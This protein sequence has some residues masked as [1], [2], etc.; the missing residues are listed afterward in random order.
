[1]RVKR[2][3]NRKDRR[4]KILN[5]AEGYWGGKSRLHRTAKI[6]V[7]KSLQYAYRDR[8]QRKRQFRSL[9]I[10]RINAA[11]RLNGMSYSNFI[12]GLKGAGCDL[13]RKVLADLAVR[14]PQAFGQLVELAKNQA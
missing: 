8:K 13:D 10:V 11:A 1:M 3:S 2:G 9:W 12:A 14:D 4:K 6:Q 5:L 7:E